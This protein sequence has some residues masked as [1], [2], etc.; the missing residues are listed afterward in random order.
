MSA[1][2]T[3]CGR[4]R[5]QAGSE[6]PGRRIGPRST[7][8]S[9]SR[10]ASGKCNS[11]GDPSG[12]ASLCEPCREAQNKRV[13]ESRGTTETYETTRNAPLP[14]SHNVRYQRLIT[15]NGVTCYILSLGLLPPV[16]RKRIKVI[17]GDTCWH[18][19]GQRVCNSRYPHQQ[20]G[21][22]SIYLGRENGRT[23]R[24]GC[25]AHR[26]CYQE[27]VGPVAEGLELDHL[28]ENK[29]CV[30]PSHLEPVTHQVNILRGFMRR[31]ASV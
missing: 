31:E 27:L 2:C 3:F 28:C 6:C 24:R 29:L 26:F 25:A 11:C 9:Q 10:R 30:N 5:H 13:R 14:S 19:T 12:T 15:G 22:H 23:M 1:P 4:Q 16:F 17:K 21:F 18:W 20:Y 8:W 7:A